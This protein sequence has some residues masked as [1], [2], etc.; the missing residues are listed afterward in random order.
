MRSNV[1]PSRSTRSI[2]IRLDPGGTLPF[3]PSRAVGEPVDRH[4]L[5]ER[6]RAL[7]SVH[8]FE[9]IEAARMRLGLRFGAHPAQDLFRI[10][11]EGEDGG[12]RG[13]DLGLAPDARAIQSSEV[14]WIAPARWPRGAAL[15]E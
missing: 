9:K 14:S 15:E 10:G 8:A 2:S 1:P 5:A 4:H 12:A 7:R 3:P 6:L 13:R 11:Q